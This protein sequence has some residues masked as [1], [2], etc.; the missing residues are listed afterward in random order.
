MTKMII[1]DKAMTSD[2]DVTRE[3]HLNITLALHLTKA[4][5][6]ENGWT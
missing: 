4:A 6:I 3:V 1:D 2:D 5:G